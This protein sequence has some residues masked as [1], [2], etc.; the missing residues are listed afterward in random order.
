MAHQEGWVEAYDLLDDGEV[1]PSDLLNKIKKIKM[2]SKR[3]FYI[4]MH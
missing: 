2:F 3:H 1:I 4:G